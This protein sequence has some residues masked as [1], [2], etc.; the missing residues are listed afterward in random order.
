MD[1][2]LVGALGN[3]LTLLTQLLQRQGVMSMEEYSKLLIVLGSVDADR[4][5]EESKILCAWAAMIADIADAIDV[6]ASSH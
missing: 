5:P 2:P 6:S 4:K 3:A 1:V